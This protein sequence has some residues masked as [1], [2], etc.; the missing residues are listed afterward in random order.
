[1][2]ANIAVTLTSVQA[3]AD[4]EIRMLQVQLKDS[5]VRKLY[6]HVIHDGSRYTVVYY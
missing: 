1:M 2:G 6:V 4:Y 5:N 3:L